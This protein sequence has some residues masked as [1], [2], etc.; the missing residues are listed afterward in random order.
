MD[1]ALLENTLFSH[2]TTAEHQF[3]DLSSPSSLI[4]QM[5]EKNLQFAVLVDAY[6]T[7]AKGKP[8]GPFIKLQ[9]YDETFDWLNSDQ[10]DYA[11]SFI[12]VCRSME[13]DPDYL[14]A[15][16]IRSLKTHVDIKST[17]K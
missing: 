5:P 10:E 7:I 16:I 14:R 8:K 2:D 17:R 1:E 4:R 11:F 13:I 6:W 3:Y 15:G 9:L 12:A